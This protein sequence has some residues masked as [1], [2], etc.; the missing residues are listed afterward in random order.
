MKLF[1]STI[2][3]LVIVSAAILQ[4]T[5]D[6]TTRTLWSSTPVATDGP[7]P[8]E[9]DNGQAPSKC[10]PPATPSKIDS[11]E[12]CEHD[13]GH[14]PPK[15]NATQVPTSTQVPASATSYPFPSPDPR[16]M[17]TFTP[18]AL[19][20]T[21]VSTATHVVPGTSPLTRTPTS[22]ASYFPSSSSGGTEGAV[23]QET[24]T[25]A[26]IVV[27]ATPTYMIPMLPHTGESSQGD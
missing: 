22:V 2:T 18:R 16:P 25:P 11:P 24:P 19:T 26:H 23:I 10:P 8:C 5:I 6:Q 1:L 3:V 17:S 9:H 20:A 15:C 4:P 7:E 12:P 14:A 27:N 21:S 13:N